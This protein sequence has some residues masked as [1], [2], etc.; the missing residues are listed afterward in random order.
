MTAGWSRD[1]SWLNVLTN[2][3]DARFFDVYRYNAETLDRSLIY[4]DTT[5][6]QVADVSG[7][8][9]WIAL[10]KPKSTADSDIYIWD[11]RQGQMTHLTPHE[12]PAQYRAS[13]FDPDSK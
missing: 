7:D 2:E 5:G 11:T 4:K 10:G 12:K 8:G 13:E 3:R 6:Y 1:D 9:R